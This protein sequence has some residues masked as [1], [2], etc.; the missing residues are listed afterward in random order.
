[1]QKKKDK[2]EANI[3]FYVTRCIEVC[4]NI[5]SRQKDNSNGFR[6]AIYAAQQ[7][8][9]LQGKHKTNFHF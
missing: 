9:Q 1:M 6:E 7:Q 5:T 4:V 3:D 2:K 8:I